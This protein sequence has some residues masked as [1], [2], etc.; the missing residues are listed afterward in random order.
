MDKTN[1][2]MPNW[3][4]QIK[5]VDRKQLSA[6]LETYK[7]LLIKW[8]KIKNLVS[9]ETLNDISNRHFD[10]SL[11]ILQYIPSNS[12]VIVDIG[13]GAG[14]PAIPLAIVTRGSGISY[15][16]IESNKRKAAFLRTVSRKLGL[17]LQVH[18]CRAEELDVESIGF[19]D[20]VTSRATAPLGKLLELAEPFW[21]GTTLGLFHKGREFGA[22]LAESRASWSFAVV[23]RVSK[24]DLSGVILEIRQLKLL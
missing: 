10:D 18:A 15:H 20:V 14:F 17:K 5:T 16:L 8:Q 23:D 6:D 19:V 3:K 11:Q 1:I 21:G 24:I 2:E 13:S 9:R 22:E 7:N 12:Q 4:S